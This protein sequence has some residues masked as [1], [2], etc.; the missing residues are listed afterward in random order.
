[1]N[2][3]AR[4][5]AEKLTE[6]IVNTVVFTKELILVTGVIV[7]MRVRKIFDWFES[8]SVNRST[9][10]LEK[11]IGKVD[12][13]AELEDKMRQWDRLQRRNTMSF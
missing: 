10:A 8:L 12:N 3:Y 13:C 2:L 6:S 1:M 5:S 7:M 9:S 11:F 4:E